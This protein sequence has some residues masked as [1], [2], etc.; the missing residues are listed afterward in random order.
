MDVVFLV[1]RICRESVSFVAMQ[2]VI[3]LRERGVTAAIVGLRG[4]DHPAIRPLVAPRSSLAGA[5]AIVSNLFLPDLAAAALKRVRPGLRWISL[6]HCNMLIGMVGEQ[7]R[8]ARERIGAWRRALAQADAIAAPSHYAARGLLA[9]RGPVT[10]LPH[11]LVPELEA[12]FRAVPLGS[13]FPALP[14]A[15]VFIGRDTPTKR[16]HAMFRLLHAD[17]A[18]RVRLVS[19]LD[20]SAGLFA[21]LPAE[22]R[23]RVELVGFAADPYAHVGAADII[24]CPS[25]REGFGL[26]PLEALARGLRPATIREGPFAEYWNAA[27][28]CYGRIEELAALPPPASDA[29]NVLRTR[30][31][32]W[33]ALME[34]VDVLIDLLNGRNPAPGP[35]FL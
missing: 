5:R 13:H 23:A 33:P 1:P 29:L 17:P 24:V 26:I 34:R 7:K 30:F 18:A 2:Y 35:W 8:F 25:G 28:L 12:A 31:I 4:G 15:Y 19:H 27:G 9:G 3:G 14:P 20:H 22:A 6:L 11:A 10:P 16:L 21:Q 32:G